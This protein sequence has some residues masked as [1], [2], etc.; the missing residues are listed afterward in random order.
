MTLSFSYRIFHP[1]KG[2]TIS[3]GGGYNV[4]EGG[5]A[6]KTLKKRG[7]FN[8][9]VL[10]RGMGRAQTQLR[11][12]ARVTTITTM[13]I[14]SYTM[15]IIIITCRSSS[16][17]TIIIILLSWY[18]INMM[19]N[20]DEQGR[21]GILRLSVTKLARIDDPEAKLCRAVLINNTLR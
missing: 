13:S 5:L 17:F 8:L 21:R 19:T 7:C 15:F 18:V 6:F 16:T 1:H 20:Y 3:K 4:C 12:R 2:Y 11:Q 14:T 9:D 10:R